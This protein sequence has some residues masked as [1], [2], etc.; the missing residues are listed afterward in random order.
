MVVDGMAPKRSGICLPAVSKPA[1]LL[2]VGKGRSACSPIRFHNCFQQVWSDFAAACLRSG[3]SE[4]KIVE[5][6][7]VTSPSLGNTLSE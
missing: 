6:R 1:R 2:P 7:L 3:G 4:A 5:A